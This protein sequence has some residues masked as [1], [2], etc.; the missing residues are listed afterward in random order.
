LPASHPIT[1]AAPV[2]VAP[3][4]LDAIASEFGATVA[5]TGGPRM[6]DLKQLRRAVRKRHGREPWVIGVGSAAAHE[7]EQGPRLVLDVLAYAANS[8]PPPLI[9]WFAGHEPENQVMAWLALDPER[10]RSCGQRLAIA[11][12]LIDISQ[13]RA[14]PG[15]IAPLA[16]AALE[17]MRAEGLLHF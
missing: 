10:D 16:R 5:R 15:P 2:D 14:A 11:S 12:A 4:E 1:L 13:P 7:P 3:A 17:A 6:R 9:L 8:A